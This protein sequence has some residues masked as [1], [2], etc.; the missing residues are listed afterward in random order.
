MGTLSLVNVGHLLAFTTMLA[1]GQVLFK[2]TA[3]RLSLIEDV[4]QKIFGLLGWDTFFAACLYSLATLYWSYILQ[5]V[6]LSLAYP[7]VAVGFVL[8]PAASFLFFDEVLSVKYF[9]G[10]V[11][12]AIGI[13]VMY[14]WG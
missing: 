14:A 12:I 8:V 4:Q 2:V 10:A 1:G 7:F 9:A 3:N 5:R 13:V 6:P 11:L